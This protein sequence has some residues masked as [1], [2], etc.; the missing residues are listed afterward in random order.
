M[1][2]VSYKLILSPRKTCLEFE[3]VIVVLMESPIIPDVASSKLLHRCK[4]FGGHC[5]FHLQCNPRKVRCKKKAS[6]MQVKE[7]KGSGTR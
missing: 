3:V 2:F 7:E 6:I 1:C 5:G 4:C